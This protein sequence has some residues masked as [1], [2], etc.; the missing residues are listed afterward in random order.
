ML[1]LRPN[2]KEQWHVTYYHG[3]VT[4]GFNGGRWAKFVRDNG[5][6]EGYVCIFELMRGAR[7][8]TMTVHVVRKADDRFVLLG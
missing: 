4:R 7:K 8:V 1:L 3:N 6:R 5:L 2:R